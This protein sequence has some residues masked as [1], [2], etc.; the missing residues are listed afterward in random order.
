VNHHEFWL[1]ASLTCNFLL[2][3]LSTASSLFLIRRLDQIVRARD[4]A[5]QR[6]IQ[7]AFEMRW[8]EQRVALVEPRAVDVRDE[9]PTTAPK[10]SGPAPSLI[11]VPNLSYQGEAEGAEEDAASLAVKHGDV[12][13]MVASGR[14]AAE[15]AEATGRPIGQVELIA[16]LYRQHQRSRAAGDHARAT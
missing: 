6:L 7:L 3:L 1:S 10:P 12:W 14:E 9:S 2:V 16:G 13:A 5:E 4:A 15:I 8:L 11:A